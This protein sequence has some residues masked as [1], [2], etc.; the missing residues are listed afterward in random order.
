MAKQGGV[1]VAGSINTDLVAHVK[2]SPEAGE[3]VTGQS[4]AIFGGGKGANQ[5]VACARSEAATAIIGAVGNDDF[6]R[7]RLDSLRAEG[8]DVSNVAVVDSPPS[9][10][11]LI[12]VEA[13]G[14]NRIA[15]VPGATT[16]VTAEQASTA[17]HRFQ[18]S[19]VLTTLELPHEALHAL[20]E[21][22]KQSGATVIVNA[23]PESSQGEDLVAT[24]DVLVVNETEASELLGIPST[25]NEWGELA[26]KLVDLG[27]SVVA[28]TLGS[29]GALLNSLGETWA[30]PSP[31]VD[32]VD[33]TGAG[34]AFS[35]AFAA[36]VARGC[37]MHDAGT[38]GVVA[39][40]LAVTKQGAQ[41]SMP[42]LSEIVD[43]MRNT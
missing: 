17:F 30:I 6:G 24:A 1:L 39:G 28:I 33:T 29:Q 35:G 21:T 40:A 5:A 31:S 10:V 27:P 23:T 38:I 11:A 14:E 8:V 3:T 32:V 42:T 2:R 13:G 26:I 12:L 37:A 41:P 34:D 4:F 20:I 15:Y 19:V 25:K 7:Q 22:A 9:G 36:A 43:L 16:T 18:P